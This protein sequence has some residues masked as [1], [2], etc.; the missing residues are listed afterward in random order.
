[1]GAR[2]GASEVA[3]RGRALLGRRMH[4]LVHE[5]S[6]CS[7]CLTH[8]QDNHP[9]RL[10]M[11][12]F[13]PVPARCR[14]GCR[15]LLPSAKRMPPTLLWLR[16]KPCHFR[17]GSAACG[18]PPTTS[19]D[20]QLPRHGTFCFFRLPAKAPLPAKASR[21]RTP[22]IQMVIFQ[23]AALC[24]R[25]V[26]APAA[27]MPTDGLFVL[28]PSAFPAG[29]QRAHSPKP[30][31]NPSPLAPAPRIVSS[32]RPGPS[33]LHFNFKSTA[34]TC[35]TSD[36][37]SHRQ[38][39]PS[40]LPDSTLLLSST[41]IARS[42]LRRFHCVARSRLRPGFPQTRRGSLKHSHPSPCLQRG[43]RLCD[44]PT[45]PERFKSSRPLQRHFR[46]STEPNTWR[47]R[48]C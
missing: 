11:V 45:P 10:K 35:P 41:N 30:S 42:S 14:R 47:R 26:H 22:G 2:Q 18:R 4:K 1:M 25:T 19:K 34:P 31:S 16:P 33:D 20:V 13:I 38:G 44:S 24:R 12:A 48:A 8:N 27:F 17:S 29:P 43:R 15:L 28:S 3:R 39:A 46:H 5:T 23:R 32:T 21:A 36:I 40:F 6:F 7:S 9:K 37:T